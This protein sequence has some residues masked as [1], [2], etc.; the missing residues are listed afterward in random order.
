MQHL[1]QMLELRTLRLFLVLAE[2]LHFGRAAQRLAISQPPL[3]KHIQQLEEDLGVQL[4]DRNRRTVKL[5]PAGSVLVREARRMLNQLDAT[6]E[7]VKK[8]EHGDIGYLR[9]GFVAA[10]LYMNIENI[11]RKFEKD[12]GEIDLTWEEISTAEQ[13]DA[14]QRDRID[15]GFAQIGT[16]P[17]ELRA[18]VVHKE[19]LVAALPDDHPA[20]KRRKIDLFQLADVP[21][22]TIPRDSAPAYFDLVTATCVQAG[23]SPHIRHYAKHLLSVVSLVGLGRGFALVPATLA[24]ASLPG[25]ALR[26]LNDVSA[27]AEYSAIWN[28]TN[29]SPVLLR[30]LNALGV[31]D[32]DSSAT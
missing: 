22:V 9:I 31:R 17:A 18:H 24:K 8:A 29:Q 2:E 25:V 3:T 12:I 1:L 5:T 23:F 16:P 26:E 20:A 15:L 4:F 13:V 10:V 21:F 30:A 11:V 32:L 14:L 19:R 7:A 27:V 28:R 6:V